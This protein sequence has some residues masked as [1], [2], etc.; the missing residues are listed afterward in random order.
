ME[1]VNAN[2][3][4]ENEAEKRMRQGE[5]FYDSKMQPIYFQPTFNKRG[6]SPFRINH[7]SLGSIELGEKLHSFK[8]WKIC[9]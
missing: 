1:L 4:S 9:K 5:V 3:K 8:E 6:E 7:A 2:I